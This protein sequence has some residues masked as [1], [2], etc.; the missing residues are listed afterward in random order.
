MFTS[1]SARDFPVVQV[2]TLYTAAIVVSMNLVVDISY[3]WL[4]PRVHYR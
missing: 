2:L 3:A 4:D 1:I